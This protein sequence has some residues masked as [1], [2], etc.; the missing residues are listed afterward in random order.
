MNREPE[1]IYETHKP[2]PVQYEG[3]E[4]Q[5]AEC[6][7]SHLDHYWHY[8]DEDGDKVVGNG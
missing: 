4:V 6:G 5:C 7:A 1:K 8:Y 2:S 3:Q